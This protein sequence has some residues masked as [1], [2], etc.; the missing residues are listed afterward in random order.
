MPRFK[1]VTA[2][3]ARSGVTFRFGRASWAGAVLAGRHNP[4]PRDA[5]TVGLEESCG[6]HDRGLLSRAM[7]ALAGQAGV[8][9]CGGGGS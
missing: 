1:R 4:A 8:G 3:L 6:L 9:K 5:V 2:I 7:R